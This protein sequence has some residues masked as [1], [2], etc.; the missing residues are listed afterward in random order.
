MSLFFKKK[1]QRYR[2]IVFAI[3]LSFLPFAIAGQSANPLII[4]WQANNYFPADYPGKAA[5]TPNS[6]VIASVEMIQGG[7]LVNIAKS[8][9]Q[10]FLNNE[11]LASGAGMKTASFSA[12]QRPEGYQ[13]LKASVR[14]NDNE[15]EN[16]VRIPVTPPLVVINYP[17]FHESVRPGGRINLTAIPFFF[18]VSSLE[19]LNFDW[20]INNQKIETVG[21]R[22]T[23]EVG[24]P[25]SDYQNSVNV[26]VTTQNIDNPFEFNRG[27]LNLSLIR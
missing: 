9:I 8:E 1:N 18:N 2:L 12:K 26:S 14:I 17:S 5:A 10:W 21:N 7:K 13:L 11:L 25:Q 3:F 15:I 27:V 23:A 16:S 20:R 19:G 24:A 6:P 22:V 4:T